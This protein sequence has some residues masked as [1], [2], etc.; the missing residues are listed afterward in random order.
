MLEVDNIKLSG[1]PPTETT[2]IARLSPGIYRFYV[3]N[4][5]NEEPDGLSRSQ[6]TVQVFGGSGLMGS[7]TVPGGTGANWTVFEIN[8]LTGAITTINQLATPS[9]NCR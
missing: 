7:F 9:G 2:R 1:H 3:N 4:F 5:R 8:G 6:A